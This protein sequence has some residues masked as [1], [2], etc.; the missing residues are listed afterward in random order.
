MAHI[1]TSS[2]NILHYKDS[3]HGKRATSQDD[4]IVKFQLNFPIGTMLYLMI[5]FPIGEKAGAEER[6]EDA[7]NTDIW[8]KQSK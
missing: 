8:G 2:W 6:G 3:A 4:K 5:Y 1:S 7:F